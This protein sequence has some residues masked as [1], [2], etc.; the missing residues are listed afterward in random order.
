MNW[1]SSIKSTG[2]SAIPAEVDRRSSVDL[3]R[4]QATARPSPIHRPGAVD[5]PTRHRHR[6]LVYRIADDGA[7]EDQFEVD[8]QTGSSDPRQSDASL[9][10]RSRASGTGDPDLRS[11]HYL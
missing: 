8:L 4:A 9:P 5:R 7:I 6:K 10:A 1:I 11:S 2:C 3:V